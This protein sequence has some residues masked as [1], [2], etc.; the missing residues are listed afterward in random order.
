MYA[1]ATKS[2]K[3]LTLPEWII[4]I[5]FVLS[6]CSLTLH[7]VTK[8]IDYKPSRSSFVLSWKHLSNEKDLYRFMVS[9]KEREADRNSKPQKHLYTKY[10][11]QCL[12]SIMQ[13]LQA[14]DHNGSGLKV[15][16]TEKGYIYAHF[17]LFMIIL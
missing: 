14:I 6:S 12:Q 9:S 15:Y 5:S 16:I 13:E 4:L 17:K 11:H 3:V 1:L 10:Y 8:S 7:Y 2:L